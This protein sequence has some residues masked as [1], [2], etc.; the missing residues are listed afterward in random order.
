MAEE[1]PQLMV[2][3]F[4]LFSDIYRLLKREGKDL[5]KREYA[6]DRSTRTLEAGA[7]TVN[8]L[9]MFTLLIYPGG[10]I[11]QIVGQE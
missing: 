9:V 7:I 6:T 3:W 8:A 1:V 5:N 2:T 10:A 4:W 11:F